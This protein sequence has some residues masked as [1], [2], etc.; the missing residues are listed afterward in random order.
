MIAEGRVWETT[1]GKPLM[2]LRAH[3]PTSLLPGTT[4][5]GLPKVEALQPMR[6][7]PDQPKEEHPILD[8]YPIFYA[9]DGK[10][11]MTTEPDGVRIWDLAS[12]K[13]VGWAIRSDLYQNH[14]S[15]QQAALSAD[16]RILGICD[17]DAHGRVGK[18]EPKIHLWE[19][20]SGR[21]VARLSHD[22]GTLLGGLAFSPDGRLAVSW[23]CRENMTSDSTIT[24]WNL[25]TGREVRRLKGHHA[26][27]NVVAFS[28]DGRSLISGSS[29]CTAIV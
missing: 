27:V 3:R 18:L 19:L 12:R 25:A 4:T 29:D 9:Q 23:S 14:G 7:A 15:G 28:L 17:G 2:T 8:G 11:I 1:S 16:G 24:V 5:Y 22:S 20:A 6:V 10:Q 26:M 13:P 21:E